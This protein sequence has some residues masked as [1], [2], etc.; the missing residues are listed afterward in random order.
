[1]NEPF[2]SRL[3]RD[4]QSPTSFPRLM[5]SRTG[6][7]SRI[8]QLT[9]GTVTRFL[10]LIGATDS[11]NYLRVRRLNAV[12]QYRLKCDS[13]LAELVQS[14]HFKTYVDLGAHVGEQVVEVGRH[15]SVLAFEPDP[16]AFRLLTSNVAENQ[17]LF[18]NKIQLH[19]LAVSDSKDRITL[20]YADSLLDK[21][22]GSTIENSKRGY[23]HQHRV[24]VDTIDILEVLAKIEDIRRAI[25]KIDI[26][27]AEYRVIRRLVKNIGLRNLGL[28]LVE[29]HEDKMRFGR[30]RGTLLTAY[31]WMHGS[32]RSQILEWY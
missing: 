27:G 19:Q 20:S 8:A 13:L 17:H 6:I 10:L 3:P 7:A 28:V 31:C 25:L 12:S 9:V 30:L 21:T 24:V 26:E 4:L 14:G 15:I 29:F 22:G 18:S 11:G 1:M 2:Q 23:S 32:R 5:F 16:R